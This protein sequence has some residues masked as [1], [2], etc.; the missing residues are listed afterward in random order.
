M[1]FNVVVKTVYLKNDFA[2]YLFLSLKCNTYNCCY[3]IIIIAS[4]EHCKLLKY[5]HKLLRE[6]KEE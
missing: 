6:Q 1:F 3:C 4:L 5:I 2:H